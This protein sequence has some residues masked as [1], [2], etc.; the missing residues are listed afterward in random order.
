MLEP[1]WLRRAAR[2]LWDGSSWIVATILVVAG[3]YDFHLNPLQYRALAIYVVTACVLQL[4]VGTPM[5]LYRGRYKTASFDEIFGLALTV[6]MVSLMLSF[7]AFGLLGSSVFPRA[8]AV[9]VPPVALVSMAGAR[10]MFRGLRDRPWRHRQCAERAL[11]YG[12]GDAGY[13]L[14]RLIASDPESSYDVVGFIDDARGKRNLRLLG[15]P[16]LGPRARLV[17]VAAERGVNTVILAVAQAGAEMVREIAGLVEGAGLNFKV[18]PP[19]RELFGRR[20][21]LADVRDVDIADVLGR[22]QIETDLVGIADYVT[23]KRVL[24]TGAGGSIGSEL[25]RQVH[26]FGPSELILLD[27]DESALHGVQLSIYGKG[28]LDTPG[29]GPGRHP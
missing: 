9:I 11:I 23:N 15:V 19:I 10:M 7:L 28:L 2:V 4:L 20:V 22:H 14:I 27:R 13:Q 6:A 8:T 26:R 5:K 17:D 3:R 18:L 1:L 12:A 21:S 25:A 29:H 16:V 24:V